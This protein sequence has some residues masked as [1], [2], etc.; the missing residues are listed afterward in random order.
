MNKKVWIGAVSLLLILL[1][2]TYL[3]NR[4]QIKDA[5]QFDRED[6]VQEEENKPTETIVT[7]YQYKDGMH[8]YVGTLELPT[9][10]HSYNTEVVD[11]DSGKV[12]EIT[13][14]P[15]DE[16]CTQVITERM[17]KVSFEGDE[18]ESVLARLNGEI[19]NLNIFEIPEGEDIDEI[20]IF[21]KG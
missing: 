4:S 14:T 5:E 19:V 9:P 11:G 17:F 12:L 8:V 1:I 6:I 20:D 16:F 3:H 2:F 18:G 13:T 21:I 10:C 7:K 15:G